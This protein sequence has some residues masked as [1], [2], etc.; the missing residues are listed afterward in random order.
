VKS[1][2]EKRSSTSGAVVNDRPRRKSILDAAESRNASRRLS[3]RRIATV[4]PDDGDTDQTDKGS[5]AESHE[6][7]EED[8]D[9]KGKTHSCN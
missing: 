4:S 2:R 5:D 8:E 1:L 9:S 6:E 3:G 7:T